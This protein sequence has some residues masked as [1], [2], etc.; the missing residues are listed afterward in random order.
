MQQW[1]PVFQALVRARSIFGEE[2]AAIEIVE[3]ALSSR[4][5]PFVAV[6]CDRATLSQLPGAQPPYC[7]VPGRRNVIATVT[8]TGGGRAF[9]LNSHLDIVPEGDPA[10]W[11]RDPFSGSIEDGVIH[12]RGAYD[13]KAG[14]VICL[15]LLE[16]ARAARLAGDVIAHFALEDETTGNGSLLCLE[17]GPRADAAIIID[18][19]R[20]E[21]GINAH[22]GN[23]RFGVRVYGKPS[24]VSVSHVGVNAAEMLARLLLQMR[25]ATFA[26]NAS[27]VEPWTQF[28]SPNQLAVLS[29]ECAETPLTVPAVASATCYAT[30]TPPLDLRAF[31]GMLDDVAARFASAHALERA[32]ELDWGGFG[33]EPVRADAGAI[34]H[35]INAAAGRPVPFGPSTGTS[36]LRHFAARSIP[37]VLFG[38][39]PG[40]NPHRADEHFPL[41]ALDETAGV[42]WRAIEA[43]CA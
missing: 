36:D 41:A 14:V 27:N 11:S 26:L 2:H 9:I 40:A 5:I 35:V 7:D 30:F 43:W 37:C 21:R 6:P 12:G 17:H 15:A 25:E 8:G 31:R 16:K 18:G 22:A 34:E 24:S 10:T 39:G 19:T 38:P 29:L 3:A 42:I 20:G 32:P 33:A 28:P 13:D 4:D 1:W 23:V